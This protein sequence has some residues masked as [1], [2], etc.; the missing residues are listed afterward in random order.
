MAVHEPQQQR[1]RPLDRR[2]SL[3][4]TAFFGVH[5]GRYQTTLLFRLA[6]EVILSR[7]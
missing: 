5:L 6:I 7:A 3:A 4:M 2:A 1:K